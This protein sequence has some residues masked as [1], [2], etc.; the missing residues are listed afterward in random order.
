[1]PCHVYLLCGASAGCIGASLP[2]EYTRIATKETGMNRANFDRRA[3]GDSARIEVLASPVRHERVD[4]LS[5]DIT[6]LSLHNFATSGRNTLALEA[7]KQFC[8]SKEFPDNLN[9]DLV[10]PA[11]EGIAYPLF[12]RHSVREIFSRQR[13]EIQKEIT[14]ELRPKLAA[15]GLLLRGVDMGKVDLAQ[16]FRSGMEELLAEE[17]E[18]EKI[19][20]TLLR[21]E[22]QP[23]VWRGVRT[24]RDCCLRRTMSEQILGTR[25]VTTTG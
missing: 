20:Y 19:R 1:M 13:S 10:R 4:T 6:P 3:V 25:N 16:D 12:A 14:T 2:K 9:A 8:G 5:H 23:H 11:L 7:V 22:S 15:G 24:Y 18:T 17:L 21:S